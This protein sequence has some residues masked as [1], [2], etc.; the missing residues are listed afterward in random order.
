MTHEKLDAL[1]AKLLGDVAK[2]STKIDRDSYA[3]GIMDMFNALGNVFFDEDPGPRF[4][5]EHHP[6]RHVPAGMY[7]K[8]QMY[9]SF[10]LGWDSHGESDDNNQACNDW[11][12][13]MKGG[14]DD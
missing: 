14:A 11:V 13:W 6:V 4:F 5:S 10:L 1:I 9:Q 2:D 3:Q 7:T 12:K 8:A